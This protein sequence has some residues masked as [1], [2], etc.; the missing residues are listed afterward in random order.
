[1]TSFRQFLFLFVLPVVLPVY[2]LALGNLSISF[3]TGSHEAGVLQ[4]SMLYV[5]TQRGI[6]IYTAA[7]PYAPVL[8][9]SLDTPGICSHLACDN[10]ILGAADGRAI[11]L[12]S[13][14]DPANPFPLAVYRSTH[15]FTDISMVDSLIAVST[16]PNGVTL[17]SYTG[18][19]ID[20][21]SRMPFN[22]TVTGLECSD[23]LIIIG[24]ANTGLTIY[25]IKDPS[26]PLLLLPSLPLQVHDLA[27]ADTFLYCAAGN[28]GVRILGIS[29]PSAPDSLSSYTPGD[30]ILSVTVS[31]TL[32]CCSGFMDSL[33]VANISDPSNPLHLHTFP[34]VEMPIR[35]VMDGEVLYA[36]EGPAG[37][38]FS[39]S[40]QTIYAS[41]D[42][43]EPVSCAALADSIAFVA[44]Q[45]RGLAILDI[46]SPQA[47]ATISWYADA[48]TVEALLA[49]DTLV[50]LCRGNAG[51][52]ILNCSD[53][54]LPTHLS[55]YNTPGTLNGMAKKGTVLFLAD[56][57]SGIEAVSIA[58]LYAPAFL[59][60]VLLPGYSQDIA[61]AD[62][63]AIIALG[64]K[65]FALVSVEDPHNLVVTDTVTDAGFSTCLAT[66]D[67]FLF[68]G[69][70]DASVLIYELITGSI[71]Q[72]VATYQTPGPVNDLSFANN[73]LFLACDVGGIQIVDV[74]NPSMPIR[75]DSIDTPGISTTI[76]PFLSLTGTADRFSFRIDSFAFQDTVPPQPVSNLS[77]EAQDTLII[78]R[79]HN[80]GDVDYKGSRVLFR[81]DTFPSH[82]GDGTVLLDHTMEPGS[83]D[84]L[85]HTG[86]PGDSTRFYYAVYAYDL[87]HNFS[88]PAL[89]SAIS[90]SDTI[91][92]GEVTQILFSFWNSLLEVSFTT[93]GDPDLAG[94]RALFDTT[95]I[96]QHI[97]D[98][99]LF[100]D[101]ML[102]PNATSVETLSIEHDRTYHFTFFSK[103]SVPN[104]SAGTSA[105]FQT[106]DTIP[107]AEVA[108]QSVQFYHTE[109][110]RIIFKTPDDPDFAAVRA[111][112]DLTQPPQDPSS[113]TLFFDEPFTPDSTILREL[114]GV[115]LD[116]VYYFTFFTRDTA[117]N[118]SP[119]I[120]CTCSTNP[121]T[122]PPDTV[123]NFTAT[124]C[125]PD[126]V[127][128]SW[129]N[130]PDTGLYYVQLRYDID[131]YPE[132]PE[133]GHNIIN[134]AAVPGQP[135]STS[136]IPSKPGVNLFFS[137]FSYDRW[138]NPS[139]GVHAL[140][141]T[142]TLTIVT[143]YEPIDGGF[144]SWLDTVSITFT[145][146]IQ[147]ATLE[148]GIELAGT[149]PYDFTVDRSTGNT[150][151]LCPRSFASL[152]TITITL[153]NTILD[154]IGNPFDGNGN[155]IPDSVDDYSW[156]F[157]ARPICDYSKNDT[158]NAEDFAVLRN[159]L[160]AQDITK[161]VGPCSGTVPYY[162]LIPDSV[163]DFEDFAIFIM[164]WNWSLDTRG[165]PL[166]ATHDSD[167]LI[168]FQQCDTVLSV[169][170]IRRANLVG[171]EI[172]I[173][174]IGEQCSPMR[175]EGIERNAPFITR[176]IGND[177][178]ISFGVMD[179]MT[180]EQIAA[181]AV[182][183]PLESIDYSYR[184]VFDGQITEGKGTR[185]V[186]GPLPASTILQSI[187]PNPGM[188]I[189]IAFGIP[190]HGHV[191]LDLY[192]A[193]GRKVV[194]LLNKKLRAG[195]HTVKLDNRTVSTRL[196]SG[197]YFVRLKTDDA[198]LMQ[199]IILLR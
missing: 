133:A 38:L 27:A 30:F 95:H 2:L 99:E 129:V 96:P 55:T 114:D 187:H 170:A 57:G 154:S 42:R 68:V 186:Q 1:M 17:L 183:L 24:L 166:I 54:A 35:A 126:T 13:L 156:C 116:T 43:L 117:L 77:L 178:V 58:D 92:P 69:T 44:V 91:P 5:A 181:I 199:K 90:A 36:S 53:P 20:S 45:D 29:D 102:S 144:A 75:S 64:P 8:L 135:D 125:F 132:T 109:L 26:H 19:S 192:D 10:A 112:Y 107:P 9:G 60:S 89:K 62:S 198:S 180:A 188:N 106:I 70:R 76:H 87:A 175:G 66:N 139:Q 174:G 138:G 73:L 74:S 31:D 146:P 189:T 134:K 79:W 127:K 56:G 78:L 12:Y 108:F 16:I 151:L 85:Y 123:L 4:D 182:R 169:N 122:L 33:Y 50:F 98:G 119:G 21:V 171:G 137:A 177:L 128:F 22:E 105:S 150:F 148:N 32:L 18:T 167:S 147:Q 83:P 152:D 100:F 40:L 23:T 130:P 59:D 176:L 113:G 164:M 197:I 46:S 71:P 193:A 161:E 136:W 11:R 115:V 172:V 165:I 63:L 84:S 149:L 141:T 94:V 121:D 104:F 97:Y 168:R 162:F 157:F 47:P 81:N 103:D 179:G 72:L 195:Y 67:T 80:P 14:A 184:L 93:P 163:V 101:K 173:H 48:D 15:S 25:S 185:T 3:G 158:I 65:G 194:D 160:A 140:C 110:I 6:D 51:L 82:P 142:P 191:S 153:H 61:L 120:S 7:D 190:R 41:L 155:G 49:R 88:L 86:L 159:A 124:R 143:E 111:C 34:T 28:D 37:E 196:A 118:F 52:S 131:T 39:L 145:A